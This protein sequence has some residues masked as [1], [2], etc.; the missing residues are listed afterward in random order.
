MVTFLIVPKRW[1]RGR[2]RR[3]GSVFG[4]GVSERVSECTG[5]QITNS[6]IAIAAAATDD[7]DGGGSPISRGGRHDEERGRGATERARARNS[8]S[9]LRTASEGAPSARIPSVPPCC[10]ERTYAPGSVPWCGFLP[11]TRD[12]RRPPSISVCQTVGVRRERLIVLS[13]RSFVRG[14]VPQGTLEE[15]ICEIS[16]R[17]IANI[18]WE[19]V[20]YHKSEREGSEV[21][22][23]VKQ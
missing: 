18:V 21:I 23:R 3:G 7:E 5:H 11:A 13:T 1:S 8:A 14:S 19:V 12:A 6:I 17:L 10:T 4:L 16:Q 20:C 2:G 22:A 9:A 15:C